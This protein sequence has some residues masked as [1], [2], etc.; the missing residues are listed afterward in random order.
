[1]LCTLPD[2]FK[3]ESGLIYDQAKVGELTGKQQNYLMDIK[4]L[5]AGLHHVNKILEEIVTGFYTQ[6]GNQ[7]QGSIKS[8][9]A[10]I[11]INDVE[12][13]LIKI[14]QNTFGDIYYMKAQCPNCEAKNDLKL[15]LNSLEVTRSANEDKDKLIELVLPKSGRK[16]A[17]KLMGLDSISRLFMIF[18]N[19][20]SELA[21]ATS[22]VAL[23]SLDGKENPSSEDIMSLPILDIKYINDEYNKLGGKIDTNITHECKECK[24]DFDTKL[25]VVDPSFFFPS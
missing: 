22:S 4:S 25:N 17:I 24:K 2:G 18:Q 20:Q 16:A 13:L 7:Y 11:S 14:R 15:D 21:T 12:T 5:Q 23:K 3:T 19:K 9:L 1:M 10:K 6:E 8:A